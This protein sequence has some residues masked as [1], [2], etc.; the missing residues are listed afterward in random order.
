M[1]EKKIPLGAWQE[2]CAIIWRHRGRLLLGFILLFINRIS[3]LVLPSSTKVFVDDIVVRNRWGLFPIIV[4]AIGAAAL[5]ES[6]SSFALSQVLGV[7]AQRAITEIRKEIQAHVTRLPIRYF[8]ST[9]TGVLVSRIMT[10]TDSV[11]NLVGTGFVQFAGSLVTAA[12][13]LGVMFYLNWRMSSVTMLIIVMFGLG[14]IVKLKKLRPLQR[15]RSALNAEVIG[16]LAECLNGM[17]I[18][19]SYKAEKHEDLVFAKGIHELFRIITKTMTISSA[20]SAFSR[21]LLGLFGIVMIVFGGRSIRAGMMT[22][23]ELVMYLSFAALLTIPVIQLPAMGTQL[24]EAIA[25]LD[26]VHEI[27]RIPTEDNASA[28]YAAF[29][30]IGADIV[31]D[32]VTFEYTRGIP[33][34]KHVS[35]HAPT[36]STTALV[37]ASGAGKSTLVSLIMAF[38]RPQMGR[39]SVDGIDLRCVSLSDYRA[40]LGVVLQEDFI[41]DGSIAENIAYARPYA[42]R[43][44]VEVAGKIAHCDEFVSRLSDG[45]DAVIGER[46][47]RLSGGQRQRIGISR[48]I[49][50][51]PRILVLDEATSNLDSESEALIQDGLRAL[52]AGRTTFVIAHRL[53]TVLS[54]DQILVLER[55]EI[56]ERGTHVEL[57]AWAGV[58][59]HLYDA[60]YRW[61]S[62]SSDR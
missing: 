27:R 20:I 50:A 13:A 4:A 21:L 61:D 5:M 48:A 39:I 32:D 26:R 6:L 33:V 25:G 24:T 31:F 60:Q 59:R 14:V 47:V 23:G 11:L 55:G 57:I 18:V 53:S 9:K 37:G 16:R 12:I 38:D 22:I 1:F 8:D 34:L 51:N 58:Y 29:T 36:G 3:G 52:R 17:R 40:Q 62:T 44:Q 46:G 10:D 35:F 41:F 30:S 45:Y 56:V 54:A 19:K 49:L 43:K 15:E 28:R 42:S 7:A 2:A